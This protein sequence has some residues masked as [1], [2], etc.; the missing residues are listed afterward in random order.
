M[1]EER[2]GPQAHACPRCGGPLRPWVADRVELVRR[3]AAGGPV[4]H[5]HLLR[6]ERCG[7]ETVERRHR[8]GG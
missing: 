8:H 5:D 1:A 2:R 7:F 3:P 6:C 4:P